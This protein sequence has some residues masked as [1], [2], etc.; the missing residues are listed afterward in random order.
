MMRSGGAV[1]GGLIGGWLANLGGRR[2]TYF[3]VSLCSLVLGEYIYLSLTP[4]DQ[5]FWGFVFA[6]GLVSTIFFG[7]IVG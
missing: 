3:L 7:W 5:S 4:K 2:L 6:L 1:I